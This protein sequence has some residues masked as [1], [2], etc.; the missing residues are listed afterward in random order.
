MLV[1][2]ERAPG[3]HGI[4]FRR[5][6]ASLPRM[7][8][9]LSWIA[10]SVLALTTS[11]FAAEPIVGGGE[12]CE[13]VFQGKPATLGWSARLAPPDEPGQPLVIDGIVRDARGTPVAG[14]V[15]YAYHTDDGGVYPPAREFPRGSAAWRHGR[16]RAW[17][18]TDAEG[19]YRFETIRPAG[20]PDTDIPS[21]V[22]FHVLEPGR[23]TYYID[24]L[25]FDDDPRLNARHRRQLLT[26]RGGD[27]LGKP[28]RGADG[29]WQVRRDIVLGARVPG[30]P[31]R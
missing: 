28:V 18:L 16:L 5:R 20:Y 9:S 12:G 17:A 21:H 30:Y 8:L 31:V 15:V 19:R 26:G 29:R 10:L 2:R 3:R 11:A 1:M 23:C 13:A 24:D 22:H 4:E 6:F 27:G 7:K 14:V 25:V